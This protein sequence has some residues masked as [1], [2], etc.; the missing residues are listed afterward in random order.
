MY[1]FKTKNGVEHIGDIDVLM[2]PC[3]DYSDSRCD[4]IKGFLSWECGKF[5]PE[6]EVVEYCKLPELDIEIRDSLRSDN[7]LTETSELLC[8]E[9]LEISEQIDRNLRAELPNIIKSWVMLNCECNSTI[10][11]GP[12]ALVRT[13]GE[14]TIKAGTKIPRYLHIMTGKL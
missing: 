7:D 10:V 6:S 4:A 9:P 13:K 3:G 1:N 14:L 12:G 2:N 8:Q 11:I 5:F